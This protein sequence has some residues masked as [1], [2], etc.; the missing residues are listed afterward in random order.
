MSFTINSTNA[1]KNNNNEQEPL[2]NDIELEKEKKVQAQKSQLSSTLNT[3]ST[4]KI[5]SFPLFETQQNILKIQQESFKTFQ[6][7]FAQWQNTSASIEERKENASLL[8][9]IEK[10]A[11]KQDIE[12]GLLL[13]DIASIPIRS[14]YKGIELICNTSEITKNL[15][16]KAGEKIHSSIPPEI[17]HIKE[18]LLDNLEVQYNIN[19]EDA[20]RSLDSITYIAEMVTK[21]GLL[22][23]VKKL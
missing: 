2:F 15:C 5:S 1:S 4:N 9:T 17:T 11:I 7:S 12:D 10:N 21:K 6:D 8:Q 14:L 13:L 22:K 23:G 16:S 3:L 19:R 18:E 20:N